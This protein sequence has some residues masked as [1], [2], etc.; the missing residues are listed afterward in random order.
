[1]PSVLFGLPEPRLIADAPLLHGV[2]DGAERIAELAPKNFLY[3]IPDA[4]VAAENMVPETAALGI[5]SCIVARGEETF[6]G[7]EG[8]ALL[9]AWRVPEGYIA[10]RFVVL[11][12]CRGDYPSPKPRKGGK[13]LITEKENGFSA[14][15]LFTVSLIS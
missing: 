13:Y 8:A 7:D 2:D 10:R 5:S 4:F 14:V 11:G 1:M 9:R 12:H 3:S 15:L 6:S